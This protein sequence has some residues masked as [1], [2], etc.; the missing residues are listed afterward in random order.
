[1]GP[2]VGCS[3]P[4]LVAGRCRKSPLGLQP[5]QGGEGF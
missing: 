1:V 3:G 4:V 5:C 2:L